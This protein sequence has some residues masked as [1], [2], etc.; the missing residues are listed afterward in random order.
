MYSLH[1]FSITSQIKT[2]NFLLVNV[3]LDSDLNLYLFV[4]LFS[5]FCWLAS[6]PSRTA[7]SAPCSCTQSSE[8][9]A[10]R[11]KAT[12]PHSSS[13]GWKET[14]QTRP[15]FV[16]LSELPRGVSSTSSRLDRHRPATNRLSRRPLTSFSLQKPR[17]IFLSLCR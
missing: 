14:Q 2:Y 10:S 12:R 1:R 5:G 6:P 15:S 9:S 3:V 17:M 11:S 16:L 13:S 7:S 4:R 8:R